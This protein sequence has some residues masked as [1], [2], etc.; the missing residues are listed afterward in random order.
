MQNNVINQQQLLN[1]CRKD[2]LKVQLNEGEKLSRWNPTHFSALKALP[3]FQSKI[4]FVGTY[5]ICKLFYLFCQWLAQWYT[6]LTVKNS[7]KITS[8]ELFTSIYIILLE[9]ILQIL[10]DLR[11]NYIICW[12]EVNSK[13]TLVN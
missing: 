6:L 1:M 10:N 7:I 9:T 13:A 11:N 5:F 12:E 4:T 3:C 2:F 8:Y